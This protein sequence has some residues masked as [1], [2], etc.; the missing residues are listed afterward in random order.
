MPTPQLGE[1]MQALAEGELKA[2]GEQAGR[3]V[4]IVKGENVTDAITGDKVAAE[5]IAARVHALQ[6]LE[7]DR[8]GHLDLAQPEGIDLIQSCVR[9]TSC[10]DSGHTAVPPR[11]QRNS[12]LLISAPEGLSVR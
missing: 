11:P 12:R 5:D 6:H 4:L 1:A 9:Q 3:R 2:V 8:G 10:A 7:R